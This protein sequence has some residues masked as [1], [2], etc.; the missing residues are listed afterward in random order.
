MLEAEIV[1]A[2]ALVEAEMAQI[3][4]TYRKVSVDLKSAMQNI[5]SMEKSILIAKE[6]AKLA[7]D[8]I[9]YLRQQLVIGGSTLDSV[10]SAEAR[11]YEAEAK[12]IRFMTEKYK[13]KLI[14]AG[15]LGLLGDGIGF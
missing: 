2:E 4:A 7:S 6:N 9:V 14:I 11:L 13:S 12:E 5:E 15:T 8:E 10:L 1:E 3:R